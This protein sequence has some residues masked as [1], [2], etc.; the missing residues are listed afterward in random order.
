MLVRPDGL[1]QI[2]EVRVVMT[3]NKIVSTIA[4]H[5]KQDQNQNGKVFFPFDVSLTTQQG[6]ESA[7]ML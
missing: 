7:T 4:S 2:D 3:R 5:A 1:S 6:K